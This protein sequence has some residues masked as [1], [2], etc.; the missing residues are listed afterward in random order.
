MS[1]LFYAN[2]PNIGNPEIMQYKT[3]SNLLEFTKYLQ[4]ALYSLR[5]QTYSANWE[6]VSIENVVDEFFEE[7]AGRNHFPKDRFKCLYVN[8]SIQFIPKTSL[9]ADF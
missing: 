7:M 6:I 3:V 4:T 8:H 1:Q 9:N 5:N 2:L